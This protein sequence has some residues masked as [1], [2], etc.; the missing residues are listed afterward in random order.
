MNQPLI[1]TII[2]N[3]K[4]SKDVLTE[5]NIMDA[6]E[7][8]NNAKPDARRKD[9]QKWD[10]RPSLAVTAN[11]IIFDEGKQIRLYTAR[12]MTEEEFVR[13][14]YTIPELSCKW[15]LDSSNETY[16]NT[17]YWGGTV[18][19]DSADIVCEDHIEV[20][21]VTGNYAIRPVVEI[22]S[23]KDS[24]YVPGDSFAVK[25]YTFTLLSYSLAIVDLPIY[26]GR[27]S[28]KS[29]KYEGSKAQYAINK[30]FK[31]LTA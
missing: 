31:R 28:D 4:D 29:N 7:T 2:G 30:W 26:T 20:G 25:E 1:D 5:Q 16:K 24:G 9:L 13:Y 23:L 17:N 14:V 12:L 11:K 8:L 21:D 19:T 15:F 3:L 6:I 18:S 27:Y 22:A 10:G